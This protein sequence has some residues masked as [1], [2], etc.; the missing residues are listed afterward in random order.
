MNQENNQY[1]TDVAALQRLLII[2]VAANLLAFLSLIGL[3]F[4]M[5]ASEGSSVTTVLWIVGGSILLVSGIIQFIILVWL[6]AKVYNIAIAV[7]VAIFAF[8]PVASILFFLMV[9]SRATL[10]LRRNNVR[11]GLWG[12]DKSTLPNLTAA[13]N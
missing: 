12:A 10:T 1:I 13:D 7:V 6:S 3:A 8:V 4:A 11:V 9:N 5:A 2:M